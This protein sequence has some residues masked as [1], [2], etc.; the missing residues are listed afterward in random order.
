MLHP[1][2][3]FPQRAIA[4]LSSALAF[5]GL[6]ALLVQADGQDLGTGTCSAFYFALILLVSL[7]GGLW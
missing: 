7:L 4:W 2:R 1:F 5:V 6:T 3:P